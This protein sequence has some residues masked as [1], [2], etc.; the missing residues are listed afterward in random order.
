MMEDVIR[1]SR[2]AEELGVTPQYIRMLEWQGIIPPARRD[3]NG[4]IYSQFDIA[5]LRS[6]GVGSRPRK[7]KRAEELLG[8]R[9]E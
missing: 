8:A 1:I 2:V 9:G 7:L 5:L 6:M 4:R 3:Y